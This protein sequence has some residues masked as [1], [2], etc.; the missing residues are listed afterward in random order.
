[1]TKHESQQ[2]PEI[3][4]REITPHVLEQMRKVEQ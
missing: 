2:I 4:S 3:Y 1:M